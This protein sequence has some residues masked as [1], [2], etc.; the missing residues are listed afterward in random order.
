MQSRNVHP[1]ERM[2][3]LIFLIYKWGVWPDGGT[4]AK[5]RVTKDIR[6]HPNGTL[7]F[8]PIF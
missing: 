5:A 4:R 2:N 1:G 7:I 8:I 3:M 6:I